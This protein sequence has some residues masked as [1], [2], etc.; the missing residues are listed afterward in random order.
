M[1]SLT[2]YAVAPGTV[3]AWNQ[4]EL[5]ADGLVLRP[6]RQDDRAAIVEAFADSAIQR[7][8][9]RSMTAAEASDWI[10]EWP[11]QWRREKAASWAVAAND[12]VVGQIGLPLVRGVWFPT[13]ITTA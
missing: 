9:C 11:E 1:P 12:Q 10:A 2:A 8:H 13:Q 5:N 4:P 3:A 7:W 6:W